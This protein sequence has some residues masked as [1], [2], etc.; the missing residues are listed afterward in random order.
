MKKYTEISLCSQKR[1]ASKQT[2][3]NS[4]GLKCPWFVTELGIKK[5]EFHF[6]VMP[7]LHILLHI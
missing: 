7:L 2:N 1:K 6:I 3:K 5:S 4:A